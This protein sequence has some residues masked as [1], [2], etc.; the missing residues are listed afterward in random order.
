MRISKSASII[1]ALALGVTGALALTQTEADA[2]TVANVTK[3]PYARLYNINGDL[4]KNRA[5][6]Y[7]TPWF[8][9]K[10]VTIKGSTY[11]KVATSEYLSA[12]D[13]TISGNNNQVTVDNGLR[14]KVVLGNSQLYNDQSNSIEGSHVLPYGSTWKVSQIIVNKYQQSFVQVSAHEYADGSL[15]LFNKNV[16][17]YTHYDANFGLAVAN[18]A[19]QAQQNSLGNGTWTD[20]NLPVN[21]NNTNNSTNNNNSNTTNTN[22]HVSN[23]N[24]NPDVAAAQQAILKSINDERASKG[25]APL[26]MSSEMNQT[27][28]TRA[29]EISQSF[30]H[31]RPNGQSCFT[32]FPRMGT[33][34]ENIYMSSNGLFGGNPTKL[35]SNIMDSFRAENFTPS[36]YTNVMSTDV[37]TIGIGVYSVNGNTYVA[38]D[39]I[40]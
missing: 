3:A 2:A 38:Q 28:A 17:P 39:F 26:S 4:V 35:A 33:V 40:D 6:A 23:N 29:K 11:Y 18:N 37:T 27:A 10:T 7:N 14:A 30:S 25:I 22:T 15:M 1:A 5:L 20:T 8:V 34:E 19:S 12:N 13:A 32:A 9:S 21:N 16:T 36:H 31:T 24:S